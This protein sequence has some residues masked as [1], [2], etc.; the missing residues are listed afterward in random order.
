MSGEH[1]AAILNTFHNIAFY[2]DTVR[3]IRESIA[4]GTLGKY[5]EEMEKK[6]D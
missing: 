2:L 1:L 6:P 5:L 3:K 4:S